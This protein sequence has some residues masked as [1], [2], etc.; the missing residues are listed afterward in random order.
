MNQDPQTDAYGN[1][2]VRYVRVIHPGG[3][4][5]LAPQDAAGMTADDPAAYTLKDVYLSVQEFDN[6]PEFTGF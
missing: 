2:R 5:V 3:S 1:P 4:C 6:L